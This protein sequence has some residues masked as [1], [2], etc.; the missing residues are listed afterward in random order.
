MK[1]IFCL[2]LLATAVQSQA[3]T[4]QY[5]KNGGFKPVPFQAGK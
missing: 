5:I 2:F 3:A 4:T 1:K